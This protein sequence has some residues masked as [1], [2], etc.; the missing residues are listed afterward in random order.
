MIAD[1]SGQGAIAA[2][3]RFL[4]PARKLD[5]NSGGAAS[6]GGISEHGP[7]HSC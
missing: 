4:L 2:R 1:L 3:S 6:T 7:D 5:V